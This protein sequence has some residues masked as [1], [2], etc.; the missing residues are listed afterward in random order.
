MLVVSMHLKTHFFVMFVIFKTIL[1]ILEFYNK[2]LTLS[3][4]IIVKL[5]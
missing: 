4:F 1:K 2:Y 5:I 3:Q